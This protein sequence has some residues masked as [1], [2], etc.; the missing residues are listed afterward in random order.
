MSVPNGTNGAVRSRKPTNSR[1]RRLRAEKAIANLRSNGI[2]VDEL[3]NKELFKA[4]GD[5]LKRTRQPDVREDT[6]LRAAGRRR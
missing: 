3:S 6:I 5:E 2:S 4:V 1:P